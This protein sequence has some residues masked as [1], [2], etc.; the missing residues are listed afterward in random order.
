MIANA[1]DAHR[2][3]GHYTLAVIVR[4]NGALAAMTQHNYITTSKSFRRS[5]SAKYALPPRARIYKP[6]ILKKT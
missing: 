2:E 5:Y 4:K 1:L 3:M 6:N